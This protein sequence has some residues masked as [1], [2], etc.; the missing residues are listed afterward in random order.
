[1]STGVKL[2]KLI[3][4]SKDIAGVV[5]MCAIPCRH[6]ACRSDVFHETLGS[7]LKP[8]QL[9]LVARRKATVASTL[10]SIEREPQITRLGPDVAWVITN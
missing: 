4:C 1:M 3:G 8:A 5:L 9:H 2:P 7:D 10:S 6:Q